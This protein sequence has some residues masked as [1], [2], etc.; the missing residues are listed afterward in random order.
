MITFTFNGLDFSSDIRVNEITGR[1][2]T[3]SEVS[4]I[5]VPG[6]T[7]V[8][9]GRKA[10]LEREISV[11]FTVIGDSLTDLRN[12]INTLSERLD[13][14][15]VAPLVFSDEPDKTYFAILAGA[16][17]D[18]ELMTYGFGTLVFL[19]PD[20]YK[21]GPEMIATLNTDVG[22]IINVAG[23]APTK[24]I[25]ELTATAPS[26]YA[27][28]V[29][30]EDEYN[31]LGAPYDVDINKY[32]K[33][34]L[35]LG[36]GM[37]N[38]TN[39]TAANPGEVDQDIGGTVESAIIGGD[40]F[41]IPNGFG[42][43]VGWHGPAIKRSLPSPATNFKAE[44]GFEFKN[45][46]DKAMLGNIE[47]YL[48][49]VNGICVARI[50]L[51]DGFGGTANT[52]GQARVGTASGS[53]RAVLINEQGDRAGVWNNF[54][55][56][57]RLERDGRKWTAYISK[58]GTNGNTGPHH[59]SRTATWYDSKDV[60]QTAV[61]QVVF[62]FQQHGTAPVPTMRVSYVNIFD[63]NSEPGSPYI[64]Y[65][66]DLIEM[67]HRGKGFYRINGEEA[68]EFK[69]F[70]ATLF[71]LKP[72]ENILAIEPGTVFTGTVRWRDAY[73]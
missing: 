67:D 34:T 50:G 26:T 9:K 69:N 14:D 28:V 55:G 43:G 60:H 42:T 36:H 13:L 65:E 48:L 1:G 59:T 18:N 21:Y 51:R 53:D 40:N 3:P 58:V 4:K 16:T 20:P 46:A 7:G 68:K 12:K 31:M 17:D 27:M 72:G 23:T 56:M 52:Y 63:I 35:Q 71:T 8:H 38:V 45:T 39:W 30:S 47:M 41:F 29:N 49:D 37:Q 24:P 22:T 66:N 73:K 5:R 64:V 11:T 61:T 33:Y 19:C 57:V 15:E 54:D 44:A 32:R 70:G 2:V 6:M 25:F 10:R 62:A